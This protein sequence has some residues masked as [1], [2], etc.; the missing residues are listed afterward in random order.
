MVSNKEASISDCY[1]WCD[2][3]V[4]WDISNK[5]SLQQFKEVQYGELL[6]FLTN[7]FLCKEEDTHIWK[8]SPT[9]DFSVKTF[10]STLEE[11]PRP[12]ASCALAWARLAPPRVEACCWVAIPG[13]VST[14]DMLRSAIRSK[15]ISDTCVMCRLTKE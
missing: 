3:G 13:K 6:N 8:T 2:G 12:R 11:N 9:G 10:C 1:V 15:G 14:A 7:V 5:R 4:S